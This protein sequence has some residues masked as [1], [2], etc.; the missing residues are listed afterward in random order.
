MLSS[1]T[2]SYIAREVQKIL[3]K[4]LDSELPEGEI[5]FILHVDGA[6]EWSWANIRNESDKDIP[7]PQS[8]IRNLIV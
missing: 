2:K 8:I 7:V 6:E 3:Q 4:V 1:G 5:H